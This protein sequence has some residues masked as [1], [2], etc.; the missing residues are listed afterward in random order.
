MWGKILK[1]SK[2]EY[3][4]YLYYERYYPVIKKNHTSFE[5]MYNAEGLSSREIQQESST[6]LKKTKKEL[7]WK[8]EKFVER[9]FDLSSPEIIEDSAK[10]PPKESSF[11]ENEEPTENK[12]VEFTDGRL[13]LFGQTQSNIRRINAEIVCL[14]LKIR[15]VY[16]LE[17]IE[18][19]SVLE[20]NFIGGQEMVVLE[21]HLP[22]YNE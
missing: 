22:C 1:R 17:D 8:K 5:Q 21:A 11:K 4:S 10:S 13:R 19:D 18:I 15:K 12:G 14:F 6:N 20:S 3:E 16:N 9:S 2:W 7:P